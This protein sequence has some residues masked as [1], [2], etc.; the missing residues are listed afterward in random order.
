MEAE[1]ERD[2]H[3]VQE[4]ED[5]TWKRLAR[6][7]CPEKNHIGQNRRI[8]CP[9]LRKKKVRCLTRYQ[10]VNAYGL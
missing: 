7:I 4:V 3:E 2:E 6:L 1:G 5:N 8:K 9:V 10:L